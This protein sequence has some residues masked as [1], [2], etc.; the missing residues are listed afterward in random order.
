MTKR[1]L[2][3]LRMFPHALELDSNAMDAALAQVP[4]ARGV[5]AVFSADTGAEPYIS[6]TANLRRRLQR[7]LG[8][9][10][11]AGKRLNLRHRAARLEFSAT[12]SALNWMGSLRRAL[13]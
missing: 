10:G 1:V 13:P 3:S 9:D 11:T 5:F 4:S 2:E 12:G 7:L 6:Q 8:A